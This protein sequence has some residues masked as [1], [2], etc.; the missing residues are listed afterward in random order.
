MRFKF[1]NK[2]YISWIL[3]FLTVGSTA[4]YSV[5]QAFRSPTQSGGNTNAPDLPSSN[6]VDYAITAEQRSYM[7]RIGRTILDYKYKL[8][9]TACSNQRSF[10]ESAASQFS[11]QIF[12]QE[13][14]DSTANNSTLSMT[15]YYGDRS[16][17]NPT[18]DQMFD[19]LCEVMVNPPVQCATRKI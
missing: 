14:I 6:I 2:K 19:A 12:V 1:D 4:A 18:T 17:T 16:L 9:C 13:T 10:I 15:S 7:L 5:L 3:I 11:D 8:A